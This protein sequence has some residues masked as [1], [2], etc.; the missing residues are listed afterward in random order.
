VPKLAA[1]SSSSARTVKSAPRASWTLAEPSI[2]W[3]RSTIVCARVASSCFSAAVREA[4]VRCSSASWYSAL[5][6]TPMTI[7]ATNAAAT[8]AKNYVWRWTSLPSW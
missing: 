4:M 1:N 3:N 7:A 8:L 2:C 5:I 6:H